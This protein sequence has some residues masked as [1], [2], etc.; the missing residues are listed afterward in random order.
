MSETETDIVAALDELETA[1]L[2]FAWAINALNRSQGAT[3]WTGCT[4]NAMARADEALMWAQRGAQLRLAAGVR[5][6]E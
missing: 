1:H 4:Q 6:A 5:E 2:N 3:A